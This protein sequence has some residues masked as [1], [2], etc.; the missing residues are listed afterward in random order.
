ML[1][2]TSEAVGQIDVQMV[3]NWSK[4]LVQDWSHNRIFFCNL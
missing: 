1:L 4:G 3:P 2:Y